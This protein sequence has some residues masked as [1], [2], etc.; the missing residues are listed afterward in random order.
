MGYT[1]IAPVGEDWENIYIGIR[2]FQVRK[3]ILIAPEEGLSIAM[4]LRRDLEKFRVPIEVTRV[5]GDIFEEFFRVIREIKKHEGEENLIINVATGVKVSACIALSA[6]FVNGVKA[7]GVKDGNPMLSPVLKFSYYKL[8]S[9]KK[10]KILH[11]LKTHPLSLEELS[12]ATEMSPPLVSYHIH[13]GSKTEGLLSLG[14]A[15]VVEEGRIRLSTLG[16]MLLQGYV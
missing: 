7:F 3:I 15:E 6:A 8:I 16:K 11:A 9:E 4:K 12:R 14:L 10:M 2:E 5:Q 1:L 13:G